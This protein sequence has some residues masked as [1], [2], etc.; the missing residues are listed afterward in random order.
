MKTP[1][2]PHR[3]PYIVAAI[4][5]VPICSYLIATGLGGGKFLLRQ[6]AAE[7]KLNVRLLARMVVRHHEQEH[8]WR[9]AGPTPATVPG[10][11]AVPFQTDA[12]WDALGFNPGKVYYQYEI[13]L[14][15]EG[16]HVTGVRAVA[17]GDLDGD[18]T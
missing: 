15:K 12:S 14:S 8:E 13:Q 1:P 11:E 17:H 18:G 3:L 6:K 4:A 16:D 10:P 9:A 7:A 2:V 5:L